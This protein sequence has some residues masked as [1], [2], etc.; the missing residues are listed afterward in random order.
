[1]MKLKQYICLAAV[2]VMSTQALAAQTA[3]AAPAAPN[4]A[5]KGQDPSSAM[6][7][8]TNRRFITD[9]DRFLDVNYWAAVEFSKWFSYLKLNEINVASDPTSAWEAGTAL[10]LSNAY[11]GVYYYGKYNRGSQGEGEVTTTWDDNGAAIKTGPDKNNL[12]DSPNDGIEHNNYFGI[13]LGIK[14]SGL[15]LTIEESLKTMDVPFIV[16][17]KD[18]PTA[19]GYYRGRGGKV[20]PKLYWGAARDMSFGKFKA[21]PS[22][23]LG[24]AVEFSEFEYRLTDDSGTVTEEEEDFSNNKLKPSLGV[25]TGSISLWSG[26]WGSLSFGLSEEFGVTINGNGSNYRY[27]NQ[28]GDAPDTGKGVEWWNRLVPYA[29]FSYKAAD[30]FSL[31]AKLNVP[32]RFGWDGTS[33]NYFGVGAYGANIT[34]ISNVELDLPTI[35]TGFQLSFKDGAI[36]DKL[37]DKVGILNKLV[38]NWG[39]KVNL[40]GYLYT[41]KYVYDDHNTD[42]PNGVRIQKDNIHYWI[43]GESG[44]LQSVDVGM[45]IYLTPYVIIDLSLEN[46]PNQVVGNITTSGKALISIKTGGSKKSAATPV[47]VSPVESADAD[48]FAE[49]DEFAD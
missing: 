22:A 49:P 39:V 42:Y 25:D 12:P 23:S 20:T 9:V 34:N 31:G 37:A 26:D 19:S 3:P 35:G 38:L 24:L 1:M 46:T 40:P 14:D 27:P 21:R 33:G 2:L 29:D 17:D 8:V 10:Q 13:L 6:A 48:E 15:K 30:F 45:T 36:F 28:P 47:P 18:N 11:V 4:P 16:D 43:Q 7:D 5:F 32:L 41:G 44:L